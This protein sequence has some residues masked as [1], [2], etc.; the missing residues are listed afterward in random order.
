M[1]RTGVERARGGGWL[2]TQQARP[3]VRNR[4]RAERHGACG[5]WLN[6][7]APRPGSMV[8]DRHPRASR[9]FAAPR[10]WPTPQ[11]GRAP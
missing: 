1:S 11:G 4:R 2:S 7:S 5:G 6:P 10:W 9:R 8:A 3:G